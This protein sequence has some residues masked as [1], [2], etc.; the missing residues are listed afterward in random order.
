MKFPLEFLKYEAIPIS[1]DPAKVLIRWVLKPNHSDMS[2]YEFYIDRGEAQD[3]IPA[4]QHVNID[5]KALR[6]VITSTESKNQNQVS[7]AIAASDFYQ[8]VDHTAGMRNLN[9]D[10]FYRIRLR[11]I[12]TQEEISTPP[13]TWTG[14]LDLVGLY[15]A[16]E[17]NFLLEDAIGVPCFVYI[18]RRSGVQCT[19]CFDKIQKKR[20]SSFCTVCYGTNWQG[21]FYAPIDTFVDLSPNPKNTSIAEWGEM[22]QNQTDMLMSNYPEVSPGD[23]IRELRTNRLWRV[24]QSQQTEKRRVPM[25]Q[26]V[27]VVEVNASDIEYQIGYDVSLALKKI[28]ELDRIRAM[29]EF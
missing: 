4:F 19:A 18:R 25:L 26:F 17:H 21:G 20:T 7:P 6:D 13:F 29:R 14:D 9:Q 3:Q 5:G 15:I 8:W 10:Y 28:E 23:L 16:D 22:P 2:D 24:M 27:R 12:S 1:K 11:R